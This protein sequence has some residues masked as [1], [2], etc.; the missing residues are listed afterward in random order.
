MINTQPISIF[1]IILFIQIF[2]DYELRKCDN[3]YGKTTILFH[4]IFNIYLVFGS[5]LFG[6]YEI[7]LGIIILSFI[8]HLIFTKCPITIYT[9]LLCY[10]NSEK[11]TPLITILNH[12]IHIY[13]YKNVKIYYYGLLVALIL[14]DLYNS[15]QILSFFKTIKNFK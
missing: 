9:N 4:H 7:H 13:D 10:K 6:Y 12:I 5:I 11:N 1:I 15:K 2:F 8:I 14:F 3:L